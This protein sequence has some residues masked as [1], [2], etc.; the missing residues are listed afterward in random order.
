ME[1]S[2]SARVAELQYSPE[3]AR[4]ELTLPY[5]TKAA[6]FAKL[7]DRLFMEDIIGKLPRGCPNCLSGE[8]FLIRERFEHVVRVD[9]DSMEV[10]EGP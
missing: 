5:G 6:E 3:Y 8:P 7:R 1:A 4:L 2:R 9:L 10:L